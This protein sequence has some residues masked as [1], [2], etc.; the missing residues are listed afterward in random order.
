[1]IQEADGRLTEW[2][3]SVLKG[4][5]VVF[6]PPARA[7]GNGV[8]LHLMDVLPN[9]PARGDSAPLQV[10]LRYLVTTWAETPEKA[11]GLLGR[12]VFEALGDGQYEVE[13]EPVP[14]A[15]WT[16]MGVAPRAS[17]VLRAVLR[18]E[19]PR[20]RAPLVRTG[21][22]TQSAALRAVRGRVLG[23]GDVPMPG[24]RV[25]AP[26]LRLATRTDGDGRFEFA[27]VPAGPAPCPIRARAKGMEGGAD[28]GP[29]DVVIRLQ[30]SE[31]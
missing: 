23:P 16:A 12:L 18:Q 21:L 22:R 1:M 31:A 6:A 20:P 29:A 17:F 10:S 4:C 5:P 28:A 27:A 15:L 19:R 11:H 25:E 24:A 2:V 13:R 14:P 26:S 9:P 7:E 30:P 8:W 3:R